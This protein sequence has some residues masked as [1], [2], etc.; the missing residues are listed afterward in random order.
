MAQAL[1]RLFVKKSKLVSTSKHFAP[2]VL[3]LKR[4]QLRKGALQPGAFYI[5]GGGLSVL[6]LSANKNLGRVE[7]TWLFGNNLKELILS[8]CGLQ[9]AGLSKESEHQVFSSHTSLE[10]LDLSFNKL[11]RLFEGQFARLKRL[12]ALSLR[13]NR[14][15]TLPARVFNDLTSLQTL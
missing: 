4:N 3:R 9:D 11:S 15:K 8:K 13:G 7:Y 1:F 5:A 6:D 10:R 2:Q 14:L 12:R